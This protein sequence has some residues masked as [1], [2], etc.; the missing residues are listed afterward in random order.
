MPSFRLPFRPTA[1]GAYAAL[2]IG[3]EYAK[4]LVFSIDGEVCRVLG[5]G[6]HPQSRTAMQDGLIT[7]IEAV[8]QNCHAALSRAE[9]AAGVI[10]KQ[11]IVGLAGEL[12][13]GL[14]TTVT[15]ERG[16]PTEKLGPD[17]IDDVLEQAQRLA[18][19]R[20][21]ERLSWEMGQP[22]V[23][24]R[25]VNSAV[26]A[27]KMDGHTV[28][29]PLGFQGRYLQVT[30][31]NAFAPL[32]HVG[33]SESIARYLSLELLAVVAEPY[34]VASCLTA[35]SAGD[36][37]GIFIDVGGGTTD[38]ALVRNG[39][40]EATQ[41][42]ALGGRTFTRR[43]AAE[44]DL[45]M[46]EAEALKL[47]YSRGEL[48]AGAAA[49]VKQALDRDITTWMDG[50]QLILEELAGEGQLP[51]FVHLCGGAGALPDILE[52][53]QAFPWTERL[54]CPKPPRI[55]LILPADVDSVQDDSGELVDQQDVTPM[56]LALQALALQ[57][58]SSLVNQ[59]LV[60]A[61]RLLK[62]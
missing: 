8:V 26:V 39:G 46:D 36:A 45:E 11:A 17:E 24:V 7:D 35:P 52:R 44:Q 40:I 27:I 18:L 16:R 20:V 32:V 50:V 12:V 13:K 59:A 48:P 54:P 21:T 2:D 5:S 4:A 31:F 28:T 10:G 62:L 56:G 41:S 29:N 34:A 23:D 42:F 1:P 57:R 25:L 38:V 30:V 33:A 58:Q 53:L 6:R 9:Q 55:A 22:Q 60:R 61:A 49:E 3:T 15:L 47:R 51:P 37:G 43:L 14:S 19:S